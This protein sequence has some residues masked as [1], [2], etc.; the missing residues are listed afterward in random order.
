MKS[1]KVK[2]KTIKFR[3]SEEDYYLLY[4]LACNANMTVSRYIRFCFTKPLASV[5]AQLDKGILTDE[6][7]KTICNNYIQYRKSFNK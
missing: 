4:Y 5:K 1:K 3:I 6:D 7:I 2:N